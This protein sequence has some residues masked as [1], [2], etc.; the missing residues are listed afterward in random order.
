MAASCMAREGEDGRELCGG[1]RKGS[2]LSVRA[3]SVTPGGVD[4]GPE[5]V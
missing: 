1:G 3:K 2:H 5:S 4:F